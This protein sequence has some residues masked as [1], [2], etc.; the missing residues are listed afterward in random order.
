MEMRP[1][2]KAL[3][4]MLEAGIFPRAIEKEK[5]KGWSINSIFLSDLAGRIEIETHGAITL[6]EHE[7]ETIL[8][9]TEIF[10]KEREEI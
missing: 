5:K 7:L 8:L 9:L 10:L 2:E 1:S 3:K 4:E 6:D